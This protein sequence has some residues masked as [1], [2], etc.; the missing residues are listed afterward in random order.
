MLSHSTF[1]LEEGRNEHC[2][3][4]R[5]CSAMLKTFVFPLKVN[6]RKVFIM[7]DSIFLRLTEKVKIQ[8]PTWVLQ[9]TLA[10]KLYNQNTNLSLLRL[11]KLKANQLLC[12]VVMVN[13]N[14]KTLSKKLRAFIKYTFDYT[15]HGDILLRSV[16]N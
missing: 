11:E 9:F 14:L 16:E 2:I 12:N 3:C 6:L 10:N 15:I 8:L 7:I 5:S 4:L 13:I 1:F